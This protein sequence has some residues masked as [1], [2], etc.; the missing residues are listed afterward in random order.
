VNDLTAKAVALLLSRAAISAVVSTR[1]YDTDTPEGFSL[2]PQ[3]PTAI[4]IS[5]QPDTEYDA[6]APIANLAL[7]ARCFGRSP[8]QAR[9]VMAALFDGLRAADGT[10]LTNVTVSGFKW[11]SVW[12]EGG[13][14]PQ[15]LEGTS[16]EFC[17]CTVRALVRAA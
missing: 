4:V 13:G 10:T 1:V 8:E 16:W 17:L 2:T 3:A 12:L 9:S 6:S 15:Q 11:P 14:Q 5:Q 7:E